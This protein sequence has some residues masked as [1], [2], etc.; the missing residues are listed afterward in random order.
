MVFIGFIWPLL[1]GV[2]NLILAYL[3][4]VKGR[5]T[6]EITKLNLQIEKLSNQ[7][8]ETYTSTIGFVVPNNDE[9]EE[10][11]YDI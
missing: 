5:Y 2:T 9:D 10:D 8:E 6:V 11:I 4:V 7:K 1:E 3:E